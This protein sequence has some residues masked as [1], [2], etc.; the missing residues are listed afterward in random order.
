[1]TILFILLFLNIFSCRAFK[2]PFYIGVV[3]P[4]SIIYIFNWIV[5]VIII[6]SLLRKNFSS[7]LK[8]LKKAKKD[9][10]K[11]FFRQQLIIA[12]TLSI[13]FGLGWGLGLLVTQEIYTS[14]TVRDLFAALFVIL[15][16]FHGF[17]IF[18]MHCLRSKD[19]RSVW[20]RAFFGVT[21]R[22][23]TEFSSSTF[24][25]VRGKS[26][27]GT[28][29]AM[30]SPH[31]KVSS[32][33]SPSFSFSDGKSF[34]KRGGTMQEYAKKK[35]AEAEEE[36]KEL[37]EKG[38]KAVDNDYVAI[39]DTAFD[40]EKDGQGTLR[41]YAKKD[42]DHETQFDSLNDRKNAK[43]DKNEEGPPSK[44]ETGLEICVNV[45]SEEI[46]EEEPKVAKAIPVKSFPDD[47]EDEKGRLREEEDRAYNAY[48][49]NA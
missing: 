13:L 41:F 18:I 25:R 22:D 3:V 1:M 42:R 39:E 46:K 40:F 27:G 49:S 47:D 45:P 21:G 26:S 6:V 4:F 48:H 10:S 23:F 37:E 43:E 35:E 33:K 30:R 5:F 28:S 34:F 9:K 32:E 11:S 2:A 17:F 29:T 38:V 14:K 20:K 36:I 44:E 12:V 8:E 16:A 7:K 24:N 15:T 19:V 31:R